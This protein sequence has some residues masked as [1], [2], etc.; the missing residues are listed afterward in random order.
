MENPFE[1][2]APEEP[3]ERVTEFA[4]DLAYGVAQ[5]YWEPMINWEELHNPEIS[6]TAKRLKAHLWRKW[7][8]NLPSR[9][10]MLSFGYFEMFEEGWYYLLTPKAF[11]LLEHP[12][13][14]PSVFIAYRRDVSSALALLVEA[15]LKLAGNLNPFIDKN[16]VAGDEWEERLQER[17]SQSRYFVCLIGKTTLESIQVMQEIAWA[18]EFDCRIISVWH[19]GLKMDENTTEILRERHA[20]FVKEE[21]AL[22]YETAI[23]QLLNSMGYA[24]Y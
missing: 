9:Y 19:D 18:T 15:R 7:H 17:I 11:D 1:R 3:L 14:P 12:T 4:R 16:L 2:R 21:S 6:D 8:P 10:L 20:I 24:T 5:G 13:A 23:N 22:E